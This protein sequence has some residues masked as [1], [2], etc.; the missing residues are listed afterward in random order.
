MGRDYAC[1][2]DKNLHVYS[3]I[4]IFL[5]LKKGLFSKPLHVLLSNTCQIITRIITDPKP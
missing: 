5:A 3:E 1:S 4:Y 2:L